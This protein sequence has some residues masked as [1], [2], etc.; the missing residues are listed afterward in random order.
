MA[1]LATIM[2]NIAP[3]FQKQALDKMPEMDKGNVL[4]SFLSLFK[5]KR[6]LTG[7]LIFLLASIQFAIATFWTGISVVQ[8]L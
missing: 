8:T 3:V 1:L 2:F 7:F 6:W 4:K 5:N